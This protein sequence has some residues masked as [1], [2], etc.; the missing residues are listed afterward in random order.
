MRKLY[1]TADEWRLMQAAHLAA[2]E[3]LGRSPSSHENAD[4]L[5][6][7]VILFFDRGLRDEAA[8]AYAAASV[9]R[10]ASAIVARR[11]GRYEQ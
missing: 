7:R 6:R 11:E 4:R 3:A 1:Y 2:S 5:A 8:L 10:L 9:E